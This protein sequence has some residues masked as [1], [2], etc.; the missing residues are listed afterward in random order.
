MKV[1]ESEYRFSPIVTE[2]G[3]SR[4]LS[5]LAMR[6]PKL[7]QVT[8]GKV[9]PIDTLTIFAHYPEEYKF[10]KNLVRPRGP[11]SK[12]SHGLTLYVE[13]N[14]MQNGQRIRYLGIRQPDNARP[15]VGYGDFPVSASE[16]EVLQCKNSDNQFVRSVTS[17][18]GQRLL[19]LSHPDF[20][21]FGYV[22]EHPE[23]LD[24]K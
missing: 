23:Q 2:E 19:E 17:G 10:L 14:F 21:V 20:D 22:A 5:Y 7:G 6:V 13:T 18:R 3:L 1:K 9:M 4:A 16:Y 11:I 24:K 15:Q 8:L 12:Y